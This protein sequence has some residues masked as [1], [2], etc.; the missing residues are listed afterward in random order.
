MTDRRFFLF[1]FIL[2]AFPF[3]AKAD[4]NLVEL[5]KKTK[6]A[7]V[8]IQTFDDNN[9]PIGQGSGFFVNNKGHIV[10]NHHV[11]EGAYRA[12]VKTSSGIEYPVEGVIAKNADADIVKLVMKKMFLRILLFLVSLPVAA[13]FWAYLLRISVRWASGFWMK[14]WKAYK[15]SL[16]VHIATLIFSWISMVVTVVF[17]HFDV[18][19]LGFQYDETACY[20]LTWLI[21]GLFASYLLGVLIINPINERRIGIIGGIL[22]VFFWHLLLFLFVFIPIVMAVVLSGGSVFGFP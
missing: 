13:L 17:L 10:T 4:E 20:G 2:L 12:T 21:T 19:K 18:A 22:T 5:V 6:S 16:L 7:V 1:S 9:Q 8:L 11:L 14:Y 3:S 15:V